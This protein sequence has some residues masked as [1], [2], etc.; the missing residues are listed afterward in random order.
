MDYVEPAQLDK[1]YPRY[2]RTLPRRSWMLSERRYR[3]LTAKNVMH[4][5]FYL[6]RNGPDGRGDY[7]LEVIAARAG[8]YIVARDIYHADTRNRRLIQL[9]ENALDVANLYPVLMTD[10]ERD[11]RM[12]QRVYMTIRDAGML[13]PVTGYAVTLPLLHWH[14]TKPRRANYDSRV[15]G[16]LPDV[17]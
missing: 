8:R 4:L 13:R 6:Y 14:D 1:S 15:A 16:K 3:A 12:C 11:A 10:S 17:L 5:D 2:W 7:A 9:G